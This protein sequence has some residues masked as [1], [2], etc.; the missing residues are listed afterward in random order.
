MYDKL[1]GVVLHT[2]KYSDKNSIVHIFTDKHGKM[3]FLLPQGSGK[4]T[5]MRNSMFLPLSLI[6]F[7]TKISSGRNIFSLKEV[8][9]LTPLSNIYC[10]PIKNAIGM[11]MTELLSRVVQ[12]GEENDALF[13]YLFAT[14]QLLDKTDH[15]VSNFHICFL[16]NLGVFLGI[17]PD[18]ATY[19][20]GYWF[21]MTNGVFTAAPS[22][23]GDSLSPDEARTIMMLSRMSFSNL[24]IFEFNR[25]Q[26]NQILDLMLRY[27]QL[28][29]STWGNLKSPDILKQLFE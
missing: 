9:T 4:A 26:R 17:Q 11:F 28:H 24:H 23:L 16:Y 5:R 2:I 6:E 25:N 10:D 15:G 13:R 3:S 12:G 27:F 19:Q 21:D 22:L 7:D 18:T 29:N 14:I 20:D 8:R 1:K